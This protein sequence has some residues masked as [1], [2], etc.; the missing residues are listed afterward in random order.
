MAVVSEPGFA[1]I[2][3]RLVDDYKSGALPTGKEDSDFESAFKGYVKTLGKDLGLKGKG[4]FH[5][6]RLALTGRVSG[7]D[8]GDQLK[9]LALAE[10]VLPE[11]KYTPLTARIQ[12]LESINVTALTSA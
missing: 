4:L 9:L 3:K 1:G 5:P 2:V 11:E 6:V 7:P 12:V 10:G 8:I